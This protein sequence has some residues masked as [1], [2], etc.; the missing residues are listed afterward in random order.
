M[1]NPDS[2]L[3]FHFLGKLGLLLLLLAPRLFA[4]PV[5]LP[6][7]LLP[8]P[9]YVGVPLLRPALFSGKINQTDSANFRMEVNSY[10]PIDFTSVPGWSTAPCF[11]EVSSAPADASLEGE[12]YE[13]DPVRTLAEKGFV[14]LKT[15]PYNTRAD[16]PSALAGASFSIHPH[17]TLA[18]LFGNATTTALEKGWSAAVSD[19]V[20]LYDP[21]TKTGYR[22]FFASTGDDKNLPGWRLT[23]NRMGADQSETVMPPG[24][25]I[26]L[27]RN[28]DENLT[29]TVTGEARTHAF[30]FP[31]RAGMNLLAPGH[32]KNFS[33][34]GLS[35]VSANGFVAGSS[36]VASDQVRI[37]VGQRTETFAFLAG[38]P[39]HWV[40]LQSRY[41]LPPEEAVIAPTTKALEIR[42]VK[43][44]PDFVIPYVP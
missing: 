20:R 41:G 37:L 17:W 5:Q 36:P 39:P 34:Q 40:P 25:G 27:L 26:I 33:L 42:K 23:N 6:Y 18:T 14:V 43:A 2:C 30:R 31:L 32:M 8:G 11:L 9:N 10:P 35:A 24:Y 19:E 44:D 15:S 1:K 4:E 12:R 38:T 16:L 3:L 28:Q 7:S 21:T 13:V 22:A 29:F